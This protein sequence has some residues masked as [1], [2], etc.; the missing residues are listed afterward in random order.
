[1]NPEKY[2]IDGRAMGPKICRSRGLS[3]TAAILVFL[4]L[5]GV[6]AAE[7]PIDEPSEEA[8]EPV[9]V[10]T[11]EDSQVQRDD[12]RR[13]SAMSTRVDTSMLF[14]R[15]EDL[16]DALSGSAGASVRRDSSYGQPAQV[17]LRGGN[18]R[19]L[20]VELDGLRLNTPVGAGFDVGQW[21]TEGFASA[22]VIRGGGASFYGSGAVTGAIRLNPRQ[23]QG[24]EVTARALAGSFGT[25]G[26]SLAIGVGDDDQGLRIFGSARRSDGDFP[27]VDDQERRQVRINNDHERFG[28]GGTGHLRRGAHRLRLTTLF[29]AGDGG[30]PG[31]SEFQ[32]SFGEA[33]VEDD[34]LIAVARWETRGLTPHLDG[35]ATLGAQ[36]RGFSYRN[37]RAFL[38]G[39]PFSTA[40]REESLTAAAGAVIYVGDHLIRVGA[41]G[42]REGYEAEGASHSPGLQATRTT[43]GANLGD[44]WL[45]FDESVSL[46]AAV[47]AEVIADDG[48][49]ALVR[50]LLPALGGIVDLPG[51][52][53]ARAN[54]ARTFRAPHFDELYLDAEGIR[55]SPDLR[56]EEAWTFDAGL[57]LT[58][59]RGAALA[60]LFHHRI[61]ESILFL[62]VSAYLFEATNL[63]GVQSSGMELTSLFRPREWLQVQGAYT[64]THALFA[65][66][67]GSGAQLPGRP[68]HVLVARAVADL[69][70]AHLF[71]GAHYR[72]ELNLDN[73]GNLRSPGALRLDAGA[74]VRLSERITAGLHGRNLLDH[75]STRDSLQ[76]PL[77]GRAF[78]LTL[79][80]Q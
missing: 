54:A 78:F 25:V 1:M 13:P 63:S 47:R 35:H 2:P 66:A 44:E 65:A 73:F 67:G 15:G 9:T 50:P 79:E 75:R 40:S 71:A 32:E 4:S 18:P 39:Q 56:P 24:R 8:E 30:S 7:E 5:G 10:R 14:V 58:G 34:R 41:E 59:D 19:Q 61:D 68:R 72:S 45:L 62:P 28:V 27:F 48:G 43:L 53:E 69:G 42:R 21:F 23:A 38:T 22:D 77:P 11:V 46:I 70:P 29:E 64:F 60:S 26:T 20:V 74:S 36:R 37:E 16:G 52:F 51:P 76:R 33:R 6:S 17:T 49:D 31:P 80:A 3:I 57:G 55:G 12:E